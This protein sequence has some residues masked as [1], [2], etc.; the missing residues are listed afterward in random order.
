MPS[1][2]L[3]SLLMKS[4]VPP[5][6]IWP[7]YMYP[8]K[9]SQTSRYLMLCI[10]LRSVLQSDVY[11]WRMLSVGKIDIFNRLDISPQNIIKYNINWF[12]FVVYILLIPHHTHDHCLFSLFINSF[13]SLKGSLN[14]I[15]QFCN[16][17]CFFILYCISFCTLFISFLISTQYYMFSN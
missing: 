11:M 10:V 2:L 15:H 17:L 14:V 1:S 13:C 9:Q 8:I 3:M 5:F 16:F 4:T 7:D 6:L 12:R